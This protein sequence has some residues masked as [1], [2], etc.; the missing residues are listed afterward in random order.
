[1]V[2]KY[3]FWGNE[4]LFLQNV[5]NFFKNLFLFYVTTRCQPLTGQRF[6]GLYI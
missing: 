3:T 6:N 2:Q 1:M 5:G 4:K